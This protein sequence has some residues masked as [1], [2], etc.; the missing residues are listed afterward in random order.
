MI[1]GAA[2][3]VEPHGRVYVYN[4]QTEVG[5]W[6]QADATGAFTL[7][8]E[9]EIGDA[10][11]IR[12]EDS[13]GNSSGQVELPYD[14]DVLTFR[15]LSPVDS[16]VIAERSVIVRGEVRGPADVGITVNEVPA[17]ILGNIGPREFFAQIPLAA[18]ANVVAVVAKSVGGGQFERQL[19]V[20]RLGGT[21]FAI[22]A[23]TTEGVA[24]LDVSFELVRYE[25]TSIRRIDADFDGD[26]E[27]D[28][29]Q[30]RSRPTAFERE[31][32][33][34]GEYS[35]RFIIETV[36]GAI[37]N[38][39]IPIAVHAANEVDERVRE[40][41]QRFKEA[42]QADDVQ[43]ALTQMTAAAAERYSP[44]LSQLQGSLPQFIANF[45]EI[46]LA[47]FH[48]QIAEYVLPRAGDGQQA[49]FLIYFT[50]ASDGTWRIASL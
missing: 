18:G 17:A 42:L 11:T 46:Q 24:P 38:Y 45:S 37:F 47:G 7:E 39:E 8:I 14:L 35:T 26:G 31:Y 43:G 40:T 3:S 15:I 19:Q 20:T 2:G 21:P 25:S 50:R 49:A 44:V 13:A 29:S 23:S 16:S 41:W 6:T 22:E 30:Q 32:S 4:Q 9:G 12:S 48:G 10:L 34:P 5:H 27:I 28:A 1:T 33:E 36:D